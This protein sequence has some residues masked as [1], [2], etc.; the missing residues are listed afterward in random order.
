MID[1]FL[2]VLILP[3]YLRPT[4]NCF[5]ECERLYKANRMRS[6]SDR[7]KLDHILS[8]WRAPKKVWNT[9]LFLQSSKRRDETEAMKLHK[10]NITTSRWRTTI[11]TCSCV[12]GRLHFF[13]YRFSDI[14]CCPRQLRLKSAGIHSKTFENIFVVNTALNY[15][16]AGSIYFFLPF[17]QMFSEPIRV[18]FFCIDSFFLTVSVKA[19]KWLLFTFGYW[20]LARNIT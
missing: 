9:S 20:I 3:R 18:F 5:G 16:L 1:A 17:L 14:K 13:I 8:M 11:T 15:V 6:I 2:A 10:I 4:R 19:T 12:L 7:S